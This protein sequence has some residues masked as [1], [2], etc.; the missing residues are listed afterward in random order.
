MR[1]NIYLELNEVKIQEENSYSL[2]K[3]PRVT[4]KYKSLQILWWK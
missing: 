4:Q 2:Q 3:Y 1:K